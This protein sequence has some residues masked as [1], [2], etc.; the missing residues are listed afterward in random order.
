MAKTQFNHVAITG[1]SVVVLE[2]E[3]CI[4]DKAE[5]NNSIED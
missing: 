4:Y 1:I 2:K 5:Y 3:I